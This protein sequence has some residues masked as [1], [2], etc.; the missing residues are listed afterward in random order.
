MHTELHT[1]DGHG[2]ERV[3]TKV[4][5]AVADANGV[6]P[7]DLDTPLYEVI[8]PDALDALFQPQA[9]GLPRTGTAQVTFSMAGC[10]VVV[11]STGQ[12]TVT[13]IEAADEQGY[14]DAQDGR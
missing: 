11:N 7:L 3:G 6:D 2:T 9:T 13:P 1:S 10:E 5:A 4:V 12:V 8:D 14:S